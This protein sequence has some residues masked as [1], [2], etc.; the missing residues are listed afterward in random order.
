M[1]IKYK[2]LI[3]FL[4]V[5]GAVNSYAQQ[6]KLS[7]ELSKD[8][9][10]IFIK[11]PMENQKDSLLF[12]FDT[13]A[14]TTLL[15]KKIAEKYNLKANYQTEVTGAGGK[16]LYD[17]MTNQKIFF[18]RN[19]FI[20]STNIVLDDLSRLN[21]SYEKKFDGIIGAAILTN[22]LTKIDF[23]TQT[24][25][26]YKPDDLIDYDSY[27]KI[28]FELFSGIP[29]VRITFELKNNEKFSGD[30]LFDSGARLTLLV[31]T[32][33]KEKND[34]LNKIGKK[35]S[36]SSRNLSNNTNYSKG[37]I[38]SIQLGNTTIKNKNLGISLSSDKQGVSS[39]DNLLG[40]LGS[41][42]I[43]RFNFILDYKNKNLYLK[44]NDLFNKDFEPLAKALSFE[45]TED[46]SNIIISNVMENSDAHTKGLEKGL[47]IVSINNIVSKDIYTYDQLLQRKNSVILKYVD[48]DNQIRSVKIK[49]KN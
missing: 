1:N 31:N 5:F 44:P 34:L 41:E 13:G 48:H 45:Y 14:G 35:V 43:N 2:E 38:K 22:Y 47:K 18:D 4:I 32:P 9:K 24:M 49:L 17:I 15:D 11:L 21:T 46:R 36:Y 28:P 26:L 19:Q 20:D 3:F 8:K 40:I 23:E 39:L 37:L 12:F 7:F 27:E 29:K 33:Y 16:K 6:I 30:V 10:A 42:I 25:N